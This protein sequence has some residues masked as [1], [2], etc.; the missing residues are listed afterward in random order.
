MFTTI[1]P[2]YKAIPML[3]I[4]LALTYLVILFG[5]NNCTDINYKGVALSVSAAFIALP[6]SILLAYVIIYF[7]GA[8]FECFSPKVYRIDLK[9]ND[10]TCGVAQICFRNK[11]DAR[12]FL[13]NLKISGQHYHE[14]IVIPEI[15]WEYN[16]K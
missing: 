8:I 4:S 16:F 6:I 3:L 5:R 2:I 10:F 13:R 14:A 1:K 15:G 9:A 7:V 12:S 11:K